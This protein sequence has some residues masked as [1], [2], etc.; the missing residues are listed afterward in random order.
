[1]VRVQWDGPSN[2]KAEDLLTAPRTTQ[3]DKA[4]DEAAAVLREELQDGPRKANDLEKVRKERGISTRAWRAAKNR[5]G[6]D[7]K[8][9]G[10]QGPVVWFL[11]P[12][13]GWGGE[14]PDGD[15]PLSPEAS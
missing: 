8:R 3:F 15:L 2:A 11:P 12:T 13:F 5:L 10:Y 9:Q 14:T 4:A 1:M 6:V 7:D